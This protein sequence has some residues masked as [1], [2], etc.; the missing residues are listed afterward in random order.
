MKPGINCSKLYNPLRTQSCS[1]CVST[2]HHEFACPLY[3][4]IAEYECENCSSG[5]H[6]KNQCKGSPIFPPVSQFHIQ[7][8]DIE[9]LTN[10]IDELLKQKN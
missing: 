9:K 2:Q 4:Q 10:K 8:H 5:L 1:K 6:F 3:L 7:S